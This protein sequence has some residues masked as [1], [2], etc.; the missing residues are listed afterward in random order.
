MDTH[1]D[2]VA[3]RRSS[4]ID[5]FGGGVAVE[6]AV[7]RALVR[8]RR[9]VADARAE[10]RRRGTR[11]RPVADELERPRRRRL[12]LFAAGP[13]LAVLVSS[14]SS[15]APAGS[16]RRTQEANRVPVPWFAE[17]E[18]HLADVVVSLPRAGSFARSMT[19]S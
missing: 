6:A 1:D 19:V 13:A 16:A 18:L 9:A 3:A 15:L 17:G 10:H 14:R 12:T 11:P 8:C 4:L 5:E 7:D 2:F